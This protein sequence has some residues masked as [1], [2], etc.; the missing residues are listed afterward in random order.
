MPTELESW[1]DGAAR[2]AIL[3]FV[4]K[5]TTAGG[6]DFVPAPQRIATFDNDGTLWCEQPVPVQ[7]F[8]AVDRVKA[9]APDGH[10]SRQLASNNRSALRM[11]VQ[12]RRQ[13][14]SPNH[15]IMFPVRAPNNPA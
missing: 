6:P 7:M 9:L 11:S 15:G 14:V 4:T 5:V 10:K 8:F 12:P 1:N 3:D 2:H 13:A